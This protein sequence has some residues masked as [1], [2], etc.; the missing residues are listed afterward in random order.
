MPRIKNI[1]G[2]WLPM[3]VV[4]T[5]LLGMAYLVAQQVL[6]MNA[7]DPQI[8]IAEDAAAAL[9]N[10]QPIESVVPTT[11]VD[12]ATSIAPFVVVFDDSG[13]AIASSGLLHNQMPALPPGVF[14]YVRQRGEDRITW[15]PEVGVRSAAVI[16]R[17][18][19]Q[20]PG[21]V[22]AGRSLRESEARSDQL[23]LLISAGGIATLF[24][25]LIAV[26][27]SE[28]VFSAQK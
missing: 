4:I 21:F 12:I 19:G 24:A 17:I 27:L 20:K 15:Q 11:K 8:Q 13:K 5:L 23:L 26:G 14:D 7:N 9:T 3:A 18:T 16:T 1:L 28:F 22:M 2:L 6:R 25:S 10:G